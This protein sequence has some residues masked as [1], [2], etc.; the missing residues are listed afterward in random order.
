MDVQ[1]GRTA[2]T[3]PGHFCAKKKPGKAKSSGPHIV[4]IIEK[5]G[6]LTMT[7]KSHVDLSI[8]VKFTVIVNIMYYIYLRQSMRCFEQARIDPG[9]L[10]RLPC[11]NLLTNYHLLNK[12]DFL[13][14]VNSSWLF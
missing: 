5:E 2:A 13:S 6:L 3:L 10:K 4:D 11:K 8:G 1:A 9:D 12:R 14:D 7:E